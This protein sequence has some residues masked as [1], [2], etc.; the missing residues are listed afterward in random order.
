MLRTGDD[1]DHDADHDADHEADHD[2]P[3]VLLNLRRLVYRPPH[4]F[5]LMSMAM[6]M[7]RTMTMICSCMWSVIL[8]LRILSKPQQQQ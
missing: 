8:L 1:M 4:I 7:M 3:L 5:Y 2:H 6:I